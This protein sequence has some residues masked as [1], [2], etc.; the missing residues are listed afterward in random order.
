MAPRKKKITAESAALN[1]SE[2]AHK[3][4]LPD[5]FKPMLATLFEKPFDS[6]DWIFEIKWDGYRAMAQIEN[7]TVHLYSRNGQLFDQ[8][9][10]VLMDDL[11]A[12]QGEAWLDGE[13]VVLD[14]QGKPSFQLLQ[15]FQKDRFGTLVYY[16][17]D[18]MY[19]NGYDI[20]HLPLIQRKE[21]LKEL[22]PKSDHIQF[23]DH[24]AEKGIAF[25][26]LVSQEGYE[27][28]IAKQSDS[29]YQ[30]ARSR[31][32]LKIKT[33][34]RQEVII[35][36]YT[37]PK[38]SREK[39]GALLLGVYEK[40]KLVY[41]GL[42][43]SGFDTKNL[44]RIYEYLQP[45]VQTE[46]AFPTVPKLKSAVTW[47]K[48]KVVCEIKFAEWTKGGH[49]R[50]AIFIDV[51]EDKKASEIVREEPITLNKES[52]KPEPER[53]K[54]SPFK[55]K[56][57]IKQKDLTLTHLD[58]IYW[59][60][61][62]YTKG[63]LIEYYR[64]VASL[65]LPYLKDRPETMRRYP[66]GIAK[67]GF[68]QKEALNVPA[69]IHTDVIQHED[70]EVNY[71][72]IEDEQS[73]LYTVNLGC[74]D[75]NPFNSRIQ[76]LQYPDYMI[77]DLDPKNVPFEVVIEVAQAIHTLLQNWKIVNLCKTSGGRGMHI[78]VPTGGLYPFDIVLQFAK[79]VATI[80]HEKLPKITSLERSPNKRQKKVYLDYLQNRFAQTVAA[81]YS[82]RPRPGAP[83]S[84]P[85]KWSE[86]K[87]GLNPLDFNLKTAVRRFK[88]VGDLFKPVLGK[89]INLE[90]I[91]ANVK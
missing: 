38:G 7:G 59:P 82:V 22:L 84:T 50:Q 60:D 81:P 1:P 90:S 8:R 13:I 57:P 65:I 86:V 55:K 12:I 6:K 52:N 77:I 15:N 68:F 28:M 89:G 49:V 11:N 44:K 40:K 16:V 21:L 5:F 20:R 10:S 83:V 34:Q 85:L 62:G 61:E 43:G 53:E 75:L 24:A 27:G 31:S 37:A 17:F 88:K 66:N 29:P 35:C 39:F 73:L 45:Y 41:I 3:A 51:R 18:L 91:I 14:K 4:T 30:S 79:L 64:Q 26:E 54:N 76:S 80:V 74:I 69:W 25:F 72:L 78:Y 32:W 46:S 2:L 42:T 47:V 36:G 67:P 9:Y 33:H 19:L 23:C 71:L 58:K 63:D 87:E 70:R 48:P 56:S